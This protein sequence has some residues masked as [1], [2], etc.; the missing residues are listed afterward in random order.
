MGVWWRWVSRLRDLIGR[1]R[2]DQETVDEISFHLEMETRELERSGLSPQEARRQA[3]LRF[4]GEDRVRAE[5]ARGRFL[6]TWDDTLRDVRWALRGLI[7]APGFAFTAIATL[8]LGIGASTAMFSAV[9]SVLLRPLPYDDPDTILQIQTSYNDAPGAISPA[10]FLDYRERLGDVVSDVGVYSMGSFTL[11]GD[12]DPERLRTAFVSAGYFPALG[13]QLVMGRAFTA[14]E[15]EDGEALVLVREGFWRSRLGADPAVLDRSLTLS[16]VARRIIGIVP[17][18]AVVPEDLLTG[19]AAQV[20]SAQGILPSEVD[21]RGSHY[22]F[23][24]ARI[25]DGV[26]ATEAREAF[27]TLGRWMVETF[28]DGYP[29]R[30]NFQVSAVPLAGAIRGPVRTPLVV[31]IAA[32]LFV[33][34]IASANVT[35]LLLARADRRRRE[36]ALRSALGAGRSHLAKQAVVEALLLG[37]IG[38]GAGLL[39]AAVALRVVAARAVTD[40]PWLEGVALE[41]PVLGFGLLLAVGSALVIGLAPAIQASSGDPNEALSDGSRGASGGR[42]A[43]RLRSV[44]VVAQLAVSLVLLTAGGLMIQSF[45]KL[46]RVDPGFTT[47]QVL[48][49]RVSLPNASYPEADAR[50][51]FFQELIPRLEQIPGVTRAAGVTN[52]PLA[53]R[54]GD[55]NFRI[56]GRPVPEGAVSP[57]ADWQVVTPGY[58]EAMGIDLVRGRT[59]D[60]TDQADTPGSVVIN[61]RLAEVYWPDEDPMGRRFELG[62]GAGPGWVSVVGI[63]GD[64]RHTG[65]DQSEAPPQM[66]LSHPQFR[67]WGSGA[68]VNSLA[69]ITQHDGRNPG[70][71]AAMR[72]ALA[73][74]DPTLPLAPVVPMSE[75]RRSS[76]AVPRVLATLLG[77]FAVASLALAAIGI[78]GVVAYSVGKRLREFGIRSALGASAERVLRQVVLEG[79]PLVGIGVGLGV[80]GSL[81]ASRALGAVRYEASMSPWPVLLGVILFLVVVS[82]LAMVLPARRATRVNPV[83]ALRTE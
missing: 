82:L 60:A 13:V 42:R 7:R 1:R 29:E 65:L 20:Y 73:E 57:R 31:L 66:Y 6:F 9:Y 18:S 49:S 16:G 40:L 45:G 24:V 23:G 70:I 12:G 74:V 56:E 63:V 30:M 39:V 76:L 14:R 68:A 44:L 48:T 64:V 83:V 78:Y 2:L 37:L 67:F 15:E 75:V 41:L 79:M 34:L 59:L 52:L 53:T 10:E 69:L 38:G 21:N 46:L 54:L 61:E 50:I 51:R 28:P 55:L 43:S 22:L 80:V 81:A 77:A 25:R 35:N 17:D 32:V 33:L 4:G 26:S 27:E 5:V 19:Q 11:T 47:Q 58:F 3:R 71:A 36:F 62:G 8:A 72:T